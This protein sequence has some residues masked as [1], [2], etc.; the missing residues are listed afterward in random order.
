MSLL[1]DLLKRFRKIARYMTKK[2]FQKEEMKKKVSYEERST[3]RSHRSNTIRNVVVRWWLNYVYE[4]H[5]S[6][7]CYESQIDIY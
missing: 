7:L 4:I 2:Q 1:V 6:L 3:L 5:I